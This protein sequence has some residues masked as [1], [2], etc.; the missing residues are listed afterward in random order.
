MLRLPL[1][2]RRLSGFLTA[3]LLFCVMAPVV[4][5]G[6]LRT[7][8]WGHT[9]VIETAQGRRVRPGLAVADRMIVTL[10][11]GM[12]TQAQRPLANVGGRVAR[13][14]GHGQYLVELVPGT[15]LAAA[16]VKL[17]GQPGIESVEPDLIMYPAVVPNDPEYTKQYHLPLISAPAG[18]DVVTGG[19]VVIAVIDSG[20][21]LDHPDIAANL[22][23][24]LG[25][26]PKNGRDDDKNGYV[27]DVNGWDFYHNNNNPNPTPN[28]KDENFDGEPDEQVSHGTL[29]SGLA[30]AVTNNGYGV[31]GVSW[32]AKI[33]A[34]Q[35]FPDDGGTAV[36]TVIDAVNYAVANGADIINLSIGGGYT[37]A[38]TAPFSAAYAAGC[39][40]VVAGGNSGAELTDAQSTWES[41][42][43][44]DGTN[45]LIDNHLIGV[46][47]TDQFDRKASYSNFDSSS[48]HFIDVAAP[49]EALYGPTAY[50]PAYPA[51]AKYFGTNSGTSFSCPLVSGL[52]AL[53]LSRNPGLTP[54]QVL[55]AI[56]GGADNIDEKNPGYV[57]KLGSGRINVARTL[58][59]MLPPAAV[60]DLAATDTAGD[61]G[62][63][64]SLTWRKSPDDGAGA[65][66]VESY[67]VLRREAATSLEVVA[68]LPAGSTSYQ[69]A[70]VTDGTDYY[71]VVRTVA[72]ALSTDSTEV[73][74]VRSANDAPPP[75]VTNLRVVDR[76]NDDGGAIRLSWDAYSAPADFAGF[77]VYRATHDFVSTTGLTP[78]KV[79]A[80]SAAVA[81]LDTG[82][83][84]GAD[85]Y[86]AVGVRDTA[87]NEDTDLSGTGP[88]QSY[89][90]GAVTF[91][92]GLHLLGTPA[93][94]ADP[95]PAAF[96]GIAPAEFRC[97][98]WAP[99][100]D[101]YDLY[102]PPVSEALQLSL[103]RGLWVHLPQAVQVQAT[104][105]TAPAGDFDIDLTPGWHMLANPFLGPFDFAE[106][107]VTYEGATM[108]LLS[109]DAVGALSAFAWVWDS[110]AGAYAIA[111]PQLDG[112][113]R[114]IAPWQG[115][116]VIAH[117]PCRL[118]LVRPL[119]TARVTS[120][121]V[122]RPG[123]RTV[124]SSS[125][126]PAVAY[127][128]PLEVRSASGRS[129]CYVGAADR[130]WLA[131]QPPQPQRTAMITAAAPGRQGGYGYG[132]ALAQ[133]GP[134]AIIWNLRVSQLVAGETVRISVPDLSVVPA[135]QT[136]TL[137]DLAVS[138]RM[139]LR[140]TS[141]YEFTPRSGE[142][143]RDFRL[144]VSHAGQGVLVA[145][146][147]VAQQTRG[148]YAQMSFTLSAPASCSVSVLNMAGRT[149][150]IVEQ[151][152]LRP[153]GSNVVLWDGR[154]QTG[155]KVPAGLYLVQLEAR[156]STGESAKSLT[157]LRVQQ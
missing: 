33:M 91:A 94:P 120:A 152:V 59:V 145:T 110:T 63:S 38:F 106:T 116:W 20:V 95:D 28:G 141:G 76:P 119:T 80:N 77:V 131:P 143:S 52:A 135:N 4:A 122:K 61:D 98:R 15:D 70:T 39:V 81:Y 14:L 113:S 13:A 133:N 66:N 9:R 30:A 134:S 107:T 127:A 147:L 32:G 153:T 53:V 132:V 41:P 67:Q 148:G 65:Q 138:R 24:N 16:I 83:Q 34:L 114:M 157:T 126:G 118:T 151:G 142:T 125:R 50:F 69:D 74:P 51:F 139:S 124:N 108:D 31:A 92:A 155:T 73:G 45:V 25:E 68:T 71:Y 54:A 97:A 102:T 27:D 26:T 136:V 115:F 40:L 19:P 35:V 117:K 47:A 12:E 79:I 150:R 140:T 42:V 154:S 11:Q 49:G 93:V 23:V 6:G 144:T 109:A 78:L 104:G 130:E 48:A 5:Q 36:S 88:V 43:C 72:G 57:G 10:R 86:Y 8:P 2:Q 87:G 96:F 100:R 99:D 121:S 3:A 58:G 89:A 128:L 156:S 37:S 55:A 105:Q 111:Y 85:Y 112:T 137:E 129:R 101:L 44:N 22:W 7:V 64:I 56:T 17:R 18:W 60:L 82:V 46:A 29:V 75:A 146:G 103:G 21:D 1:G 84:D 149:V 123:G 62:G 90:N